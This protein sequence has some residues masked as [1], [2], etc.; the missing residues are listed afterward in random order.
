MGGG[1]IALLA[2]QTPLL[3]LSPRGRGKRR[4]VNRRRP[5]RGSIPAWAGETV[6]RDGTSRTSRV[7][8]R[9]GGGNRSST[10]LLAAVRG[11]SPRGRGKRLA[12]YD[13]QVQA[14][15]I[16][17]WAGE[18]AFA[19]HSPS[20]REV[21][22]RVGGG[23]TRDGKPATRQHG[24]S[25]RGR[26]KRGKG[27]G[28]GVVQRSIPAWAGETQVRP[29]LWGLHSVYPRVGGGNESAGL[30]RQYPGGLSP[31]GRGKPRAKTPKRNRAGSIPAW[32]GETPGKSGFSARWA[33]YP[34]VG[35]GN[36]DPQHIGQPQ[37]GLSPRG[38]GKHEHRSNSGNPRR[39]IPAWAGE[40]TTQIE[41]VGY[42]RVYPR[43]GG[44]NSYRVEASL[45]STGLSPRGRGKR[46]RNGN[47]PLFR[48]SI[49][50]WAGETGLAVISPAEKGVYPRV[51]GGNPGQLPPSPQ[52][53]G[54]SPRGR[55][56]PAH[57]GER[58]TGIWSIPAWAGETRPP[59]PA[60]TAA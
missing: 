10:R 34:R 38:R 6:P 41:G 57:P 5:R 3:G 7:Y 19:G 59:S 8:P 9:V 42:K 2:A 55:G 24:L 14:G 37:Q 29:G 47:W 1:N 40:T 46:G 12:G 48:R 22:P 58:E 50:A 44:G 25:P 18:T 17:A 15:S 53:R 11:L 13:R 16:P 35:G 45:Q 31:R 54:L 36:Q 23:N 32:A 33:V 26:G 60:V 20:A 43:V 49:P 30:D 28:K 21:Y 52:A 51:G 4:G 39:S 27:G 56:K